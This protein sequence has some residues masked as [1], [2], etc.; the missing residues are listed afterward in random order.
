[1]DQHYEP[2]A[3]SPCDGDGELV[4]S[5]LGSPPVLLGRKLVGQGFESA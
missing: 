5:A 4:G 1:L 2:L 3:S